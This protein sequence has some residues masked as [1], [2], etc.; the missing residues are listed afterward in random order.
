MLIHTFFAMCYKL[1]A[2]KKK[3]PRSW[4]M[5]FAGLC[6]ANQCGKTLTPTDGKSIQVMTDPEM[7]QKID[8]L[9]DPVPFASQGGHFLWFLA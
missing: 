6:K 8:N 5:R 9:F 4:V 2:R 3:R 1:Y 7:E